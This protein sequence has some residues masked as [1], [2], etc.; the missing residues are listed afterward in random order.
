MPTPKPITAI[1]GR[2]SQTGSGE[3]GTYRVA[4][5]KL[6]EGLY[7]V[8]LLAPAQAT[9][10]TGDAALKS[11]FDVRNVSTEQL[12]LQ[13]RPDLMA[14]IA[15]D[16]GGSPL[17][18]DAVGQLRREFERYRTVDRPP[19]TTRTTA[20]DRWWVFVGLITVWGAAWAL[21]RSGGLV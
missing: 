19:Q 7:Q 5:G 20:W 11:V 14:R 13:A 15:A 3:A 10:E 21:R 18:P 8:R 1:I 9:A 4:F 16:S 17:G 6:P 12:D 2:T